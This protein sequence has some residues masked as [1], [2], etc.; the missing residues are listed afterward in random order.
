METE[1][2]FNKKAL[3]FKPPMLPEKEK[4][5]LRKQFGLTENQN[6]KYFNTILFKYLDI[7]FNVKISFEVDREVRM[8]LVSD[9]IDKEDTENEIGEA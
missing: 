9:L 2:I 8:N 7:E 3:I 5:S 4:R 1:N 6:L